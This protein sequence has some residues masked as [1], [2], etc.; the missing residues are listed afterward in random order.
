MAKL[1]LVASVKR[2]LPLSSFSVSSGANFL[3]PECKKC[4]NDLSK[5]RNR[6]RYKYGMPMIIIINAQYVRKMRQ[7][8]QE[9]VDKE[10]VL[11]S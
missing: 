9:K 3:R 4:N 5:V 8:W 1:K 6:L 7:R 10:M 11:G 2:R